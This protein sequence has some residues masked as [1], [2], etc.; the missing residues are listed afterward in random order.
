MLINGIID[1]L[2]FNFSIKLKTHKFHI[3]QCSTEIQ[4]LNLTTF[5][6][7]NVCVILMFGLGLD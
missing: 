3:E 4:W 1:C 5:S 7:A 6:Q 2:V